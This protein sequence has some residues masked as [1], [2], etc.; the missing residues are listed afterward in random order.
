VLVGKSRGPQEEG[1]LFLHKM[2]VY[3]S[4][5]SRGAIAHNLQAA[6]DLGV[7]INQL[8]GLATSC[9]SKDGMVAVLRKTY[10]AQAFSIIPPS[11]RLP[12]D[13]ADLEA[14]VDSKARCQPASC[15]PV[16]TRVR[17]AQHTA[18]GRCPAPGTR[19]RLP[20]AFAGGRGRRLGGQAAAAPRRGRAHAARP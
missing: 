9:V 6:A 2:D 17:T 20:L 18:R 7:R 16:C 8:P 13:A 19:P 14:Y 11:F 12:E 1:H 4:S 15:R 3:W 10:G 5:G